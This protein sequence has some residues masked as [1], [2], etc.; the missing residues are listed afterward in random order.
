[1]QE[2]AFKLA[3]KHEKY[4]DICV[5]TLSSPPSCQILG[6]WAHKIHIFFVSILSI[7]SSH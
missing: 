1:M 4:G 3:F 6:G 5:Y 2:K 7:L